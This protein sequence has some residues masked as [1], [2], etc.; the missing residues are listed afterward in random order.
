MAQL[1]MV[2]KR[3]VARLLE[4]DC[5]NLAQSAAYTAMV[6]LFPALVV[7][8]A[9][10]AQMPDVTPLK[11]EVGAFFDEVMP[12]NVF[13][14][15]TSYFVNANVDANGKPHTAGALIAAAIVSL[16]GA[17]SSIATLME[18]LH[19]AADVPFRHWSFW[20]KRTRSLLLVPLSLVPLGIA[21]ILVVFGR[22]IT[23]W[24]AE[25]M[26]NPVKPAFFAVAIAV[27]WI[28]A[29]AGVVGLTALIYHWG[30]PPMARL[31]QRRSWVKTLPGAVVATAMWF[32]TT[33]AFGL[34][35]TRVADYSAVY[36]SLGAGIALLF[37]LYIV[38]LSVLCGAE[39][40]AQLSR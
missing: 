16:I 13:P 32:L 22:W 37:W 28:V 31:G 25:Y 33:L 35:V 23:E 2:L 17:S 7:A 19:R 39:F 21:S 12:A 20:R 24:L 18:G 27:R 14:V 10:I 11:V 15:L 40:N 6:A 36:G 9:L 30:V 4:H 5:L 3:V 1:P 34:Y 26:A 38:F 8:A 29:L